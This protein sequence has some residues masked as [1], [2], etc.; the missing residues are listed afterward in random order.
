MIPY[1]HS[2]RIHYRHYVKIKTVQ[3]LNTGNN[4][5]NYCLY[6]IIRASFSWMNPT[7]DNY[8]PFYI[9]LIIMPLLTMTRNLN[10]GNIN[11]PQ[12]WS[13]T[14][15]L[16]IR[17]H[18]QPVN[19]SSK[20]AVTIRRHSSHQYPMSLPLKLIYKLK[21][22]T[23]LNLIVLIPHCFPL[24]YP[25]SLILTD[26]WLHSMLIQRVSLAKSVDPKSNL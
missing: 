25:L 18:W 21:V 8:C 5:L 2:I 6:R 10:Q 16:Y 19:K 26:V 9:F 3:Q 4:S 24:L 13:D 12:T 23:F 15:Y 7:Q 17:I 11:S 14:L 22:V 20:F 1:N